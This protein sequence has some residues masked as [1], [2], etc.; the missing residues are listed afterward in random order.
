M[1]RQ[2]ML[3]IMTAFAQLERDKMIERTRAGLVVGLMTGSRDLDRRCF[4][5]HVVVVAVATHA[6]DERRTD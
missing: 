2:A 5:R 4:Q 3:I 1:D 6:A